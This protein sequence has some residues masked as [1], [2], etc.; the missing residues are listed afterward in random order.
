MKLNYGALYPGLIVG[1]SG[2][3]LDPVSCLI[4]GTEAGVAHAFDPAVA[5]HVFCVCKEHD[6]LYGMS[7]DLEGLS[8]DDLNTWEHGNFGDHVV[9][10]ANPGVV[11]DN[12]ALQDKIN[13][14][15]LKSH[16]IGIKYDV[17][18]LFR[19]WGI[20][21]PDDPKKLVCSDFTRIMLQTFGLAHPK[22]WDADF[23]MS[24]PWDQQIYF[25]NANK[26]LPNWRAE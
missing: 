1:A 6:L 8:E 2:S 16:A 12:Y 18:E 21:T 9:W 22:E 14:W 4:R 5:S 23:K 24:D 26:L 15:L 11:W 3:I 20:N 17:L 13:Q 7:M 19:W 10:V 25:T